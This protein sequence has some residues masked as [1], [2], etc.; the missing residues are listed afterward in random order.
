[1]AKEHPKFKKM[2]K[3][4][5]KY[6]IEQAVALPEWSSAKGHNHIDPEAQKSKS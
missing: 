1:V 2:L 3:I 5:Q 4:W 6:A